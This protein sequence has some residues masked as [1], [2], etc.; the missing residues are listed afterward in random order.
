MAWMVSCKTHWDQVWNNMARRYIDGGHAAIDVEQIIST[1][2]ARCQ[3]TYALQLEF[4]QTQTEQ[5][6]MDMYQAFPTWMNDLLSN[7]EWNVE[8]IFNPSQ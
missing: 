3:Q 2:K 8:Q 5:G 1:R 6:A 4:M 7:S